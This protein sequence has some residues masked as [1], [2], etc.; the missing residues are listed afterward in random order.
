ML[1]RSK[2]RAS[3]GEML[4]SCRGGVRNFAACSLP[5]AWIPWI[6]ASIIWL[7]VA[8]AQPQMARRCWPVRFVADVLRVWVIG[9]VPFNG[10]RSVVCRPE[11]LDACGA[12]AGAPSAEAGEQV[13]C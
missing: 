3:L 4:I 7:K 6:S 2:A 11:N 10:Y 13:D 1:F 9:A 12:R 8:S 5:S